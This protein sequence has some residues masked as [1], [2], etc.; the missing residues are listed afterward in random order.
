MNAITI[1]T[2][3]YIGVDELY[4]GELEHDQCED[5]YYN[6]CEFSQKHFVSGDLHK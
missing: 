5:N 3:L 6:F 2:Q 1:H 4:I